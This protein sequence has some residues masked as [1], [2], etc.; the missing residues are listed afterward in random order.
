MTPTPQVD[1][2]DFDAL[3]EQVDHD[4]GFLRELIGIF[5]ESRASQM[6]SLCRSVAESDAEG[7]RLHAHA[8]KGMLL[9]LGATISVETARDL[10]NAGRDNRLLEVSR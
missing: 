9:S 1:P 2:V 10:E 7:I 8:M 6:D 3:M 4:S 5:R